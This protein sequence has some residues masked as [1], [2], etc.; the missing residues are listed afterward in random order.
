MSAGRVEFASERRTHRRSNGEQRD[1]AAA[2]IDRR[3]EPALSFTQHPQMDRVYG[4]CRL[5]YKVQGLGPWRVRAEP[6]LLP[7]DLDMTA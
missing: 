6:G 2:G 3:R 5:N 1:H 4:K 7:F